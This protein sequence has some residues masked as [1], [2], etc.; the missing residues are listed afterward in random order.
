[1]TSTHVTSPAST[2]QPSGALLGAVVKDSPAALA[3]MAAG[4]VV[5]AVDGAPVHSMSELMTR[6]YPDPPGMSVAVTFERSQA[7]ETVDVQLAEP[8]AE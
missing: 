5:M 3:G 8:D 1:V 2:S 6:L 4:D 7:T